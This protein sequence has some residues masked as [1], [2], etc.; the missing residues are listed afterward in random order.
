L[1]PY[2]GAGV[3]TPRPPGGDGGRGPLAREERHLKPTK[4]PR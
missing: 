3:K 2:K 4:G 1:S